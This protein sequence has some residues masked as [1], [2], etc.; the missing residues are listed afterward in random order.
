LA[1]DRLL[2][3]EARELLLEIALAAQVIGLGVRLEVVD[4]PLEAVEADQRV[5]DR[6]VV[7]AFAHLEA[8]RRG[9][10]P[11]RDGLLARLRVDEL[12]LETRDVVR[13]LLEAFADRL[14]LI[15][16]PLRRRRDLGLLGERGLREVVAVLVE[17]ELGLALPFG[18]L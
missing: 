16:E 13:K 5:V 18:G 7:Q 14:V 17:R 6:I 1:A 10:M 12:L 11:R 2:A 4:A 3:L 15:L 8:P 9:L